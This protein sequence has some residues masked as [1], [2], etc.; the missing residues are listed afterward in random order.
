[1]VGH[2]GTTADTRRIRRLKT[3][4]AIEVEASA[5]GV[6]LRVCLHGTWQDVSLARRPWRIEQQWWRGEPVR[7]DYYRVAPQDGPALT[8]YRDMISGEWYRQEY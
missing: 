2:P 1:M 7:R 3:P 4:G 6:P 8:V 5:D